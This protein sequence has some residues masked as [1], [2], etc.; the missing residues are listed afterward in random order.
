MGSSTAPTRIDSNFHYVKSAYADKSFKNA[1]TED[2]IIQDDIDLIYEFITE[3]QASQNIGLLRTN[4]I[5][6]TLVNWRRFI[7]PYRDANISDVYK[8]ISDLK[9]AKT[10]KGLPYKTNTIHDY[11]IFL[12]RFSLWLIENNY[13]SLPKEKIMRIRP[14]RIDSQTKQPDQ[15]LSKEEIEALLKACLTSRDR[16]LIALLYESGCRIGE[17]ARLTWGRVKFDDYGVILTVEDTK[18]NTQR[19]VRLVMTKPYFSAWRQDY[20][21]DS[22]DDALVFI[23][24]RKTPLKH[25]AVMK[26]LERLSD[27]AGIKKHITPHIFRHSRITHLIND[28]MNESVIKLMM[29][30]NINTKMFHTYAHLTGGDIDRE[31]LGSYGIVQKEEKE[32]HVLEP[33]MCANCMTIN[34]PGAEYCAHCGKSLSENAAAT[35]EEMAEDVLSNPDML[36]KMITEILEERL[37][38][39]SKP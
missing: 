22:K 38:A 11:I 9:Q 19:Y 15:L 23:T 39:A 4:K 14:P 10:Q 18:C 16:A 34:P 37:K 29:W 25:G 5:I 7:C 1:L 27:R 8:A 6:Y 12:K 32:N 28:G 26:I 35:I 30:G 31:V 33:V 13:S 21:F 20:P 36:R 24:H 3:L 2:R 17:I